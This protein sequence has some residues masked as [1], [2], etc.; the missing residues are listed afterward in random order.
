VPTCTLNLID[1]GGSE[2]L[3]QL[4]DFENRAS[5]KQKE[6]SFQAKGIF[7]LDSIVSILSD[8]G[9]IHD[10]T[11]VPYRESKLSRFLMPYLEGDSSMLW[12][13]SVSPTDQNYR[14]NM[15]TCDF[16]NRVSRIVQ[17]VSPK[18]VPLED[19]T[20]YQIKKSIAIMKLRM[21]KLDLLIS[22]K[23]H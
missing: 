2:P 23:E 1:L 18:Q 10:Q 7:T 16:A 21:S 20:L 15:K 17:K 14:F 8:P 22:K 3:S 12:V 13:C 11:W 4:G 5:Q 6:H 9:Q 19:S